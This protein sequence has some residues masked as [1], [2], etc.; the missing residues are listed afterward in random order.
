MKKAKEILIAVTVTIIGLWLAAQGNEPKSCE[1][2]D[3]QCET[4]R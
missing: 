1:P 4:T 2:D 3:A